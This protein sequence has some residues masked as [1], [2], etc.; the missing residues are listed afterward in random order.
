MARVFFDYE[1]LKLGPVFFRWRFTM[2]KSIVFLARNS[3]LLHYS[4]GKL[5]W[6]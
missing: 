1:P 5:I 3:L 4:M 2:E 6:Q